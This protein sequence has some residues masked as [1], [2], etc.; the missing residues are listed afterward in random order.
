RH[1]G[2]RGVRGEHF[3]EQRT[4]GGAARSAPARSRGA[5][6]RGQRP[7][8]TV[9][10][11]QFQ[12][13]RHARAAGDRRLDPPRTLNTSVMTLKLYLHPLSS[14]CHKVLIAFYENDTPFERVII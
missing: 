13:H 6:V 8:K 12:D 14:Y 11:A 10:A 2:I 7:R 5:A 9:L 3:P 4:A 1:A